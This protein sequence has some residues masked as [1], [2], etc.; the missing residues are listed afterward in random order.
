[1]I[2]ARALWIAGLERQETLLATTLLAAF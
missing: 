2:L 1:L